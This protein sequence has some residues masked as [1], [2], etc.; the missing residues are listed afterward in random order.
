MYSLLEYILIKS[1]E[2]T[3]KLMM[4]FK[5]EMRYES[6]TVF[7]KGFLILKKIKEVKSKLNNEDLIIY[8]FL[9]F[10]NDQ[11]EY[12]IDDELFI[13]AVLNGIEYDPETTYKESHNF[14]GIISSRI[15]KIAIELFLFELR[16][17]WNKLGVS[18]TD[19]KRCALLIKETIHIENTNKIV[20]IKLS[21]KFA[22]LHELGLID[23]LNENFP[24]VT[25]RVVGKIL[26]EI[27]S[28]GSSETWRRLYSD[29]ITG[30]ERAKGYPLKRKNIEKAQALLNKIVYGS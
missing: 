8:Q 19:V 27:T 9:R 1:S 12:D 18:E 30:E 21:E 5:D 25:Q 2:M 7:D 26:K 11:V 23:K 16:M 29:Y 24:D 20:L 6:D 15:N 3:D 13:G 28:Q 14:G 4:D 10:Q 17:I 22:F